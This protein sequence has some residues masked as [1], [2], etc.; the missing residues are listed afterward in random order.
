VLWN[1]IFNSCITAIVA[2]QQ[3]LRDVKGDAVQGRKTFS[4]T[5]GSPAAERLIAKMIF[6]AL[7]CV[8]LEAT[9]VEQVRVVSK[10]T[11]I[12][13]N[14]LLYGIMIVRNWYSYDVRRTYEFYNQL[15]N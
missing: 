7:L 11:Y 2:F 3:D 6:C 12:I 1:I 10:S 14:S 4:V 15:I 13:I 9:L 8:L 5:M